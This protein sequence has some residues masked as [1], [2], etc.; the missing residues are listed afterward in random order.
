M[1]K[2]YVTAHQTHHFLGRG[3]VGCSDT[4]DRSHISETIGADRTAQEPVAN[5]VNVGHGV[6]VG[7]DVE[8]RT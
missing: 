2:S 8:A 6:G 7:E 1:S 3:N 5:D 4:C